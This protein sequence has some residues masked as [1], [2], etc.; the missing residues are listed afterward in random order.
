MEYDCCIFC[1]NTLANVVELG[2][3][4]RDSLG[5]LK[6]PCS[7][8]AKDDATGSALTVSGVE[9]LATFVKEG[10]SGIESLILQG[11]SSEVAG[12]QEGDVGEDMEEALVL[13]GNGCIVLG[14]LLRTGEVD[15]PTSTSHAPAVKVEDD[16]ISRKILN[17]T[18][19]EFI[20]RTLNAFLCMME[21]RVGMVSLGVGAPV[22]KLI[23]ELRE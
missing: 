12:R 4:G 7:S 16:E 9:W 1:L 17:V 3:S 5:G 6:V 11:A 2:R 20:W 22:I 10:L 21:A 14:V 23:K 18:T 13:G 8:G 15:L 19:K